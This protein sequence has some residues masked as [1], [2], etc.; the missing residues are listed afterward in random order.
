[1]GTKIARTF[2]E[3]VA[4]GIP[5]E[6]PERPAEDPAVNRAPRRRDVLSPGE[7]ALA[8]RNALR[9]VPRRHHA[10]LAPELA[11]ELHEDGRIYMRRYRPHYPMHARP[12]GDYP[13]R[14]TQAAAIMLMV[15]NNLD[16]NV[17]Q[18]PYE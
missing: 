4:E 6:L 13:A 10:A 11:Q 2:A 8:L 18:H 3:Q 7:K 5:G 12:I 16:P 9:Y 14:T 1:M 15:Q 17:A